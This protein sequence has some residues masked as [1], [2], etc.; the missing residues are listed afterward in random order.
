MMSRFPYLKSFLNLFFPDLCVVCR[1]AL[2]EDETYFCLD[3]SLALPETDYH[4]IP[5]NPAMDRFA[6]KIVLQKATSYL[7]YNKS[8]IGPKVIGEIKY[9]GNK[10]FGFWLGAFYADI[11]SS[12]CFLGDIDRIV[13]VPL[14]PFKQWKRGF[15]QAERIAA[16]ISRSSGIPLESG[17]LVRARANPTQTRK[18]LFERWMNTRDVFSLKN[19]DRLEGKHI[20]LVDDVLTTGSTLEAAAGSLL[21]IRDLKVS[22]LTLAIA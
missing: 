8:G 15:N 1:R 20:L 16:G 3:C 9:R 6:G 4:R 21:G 18:S 14:H 10:D 22:I 5:D 7:Y 2:M 12:S 19:T 17:V 13:P 11:L